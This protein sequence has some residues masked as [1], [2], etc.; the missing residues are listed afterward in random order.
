MTKY[1]WTALTAIAIVVAAVVAI[2]GISPVWTIAAAAVALLSLAMLVRSLMLPLRTIRNGMDLLRGQD[3]ASTLRKVGQSDADEMV[4]LYNALIGNMKAERL[5]NIEQADFLGKL[6]DASPMGIAI[7]DFDGRI[8]EANSSFRRMETATVAAALD[9]LA[10]GQNVTVRQ[11]DP[12]V[13][14]C[15]C[16]YF[17]DRGFRRTFYM[18][19]RLTDEVIKAETAVFNKIVRTMSHEVNNTMGGVVSVLETLADIHAAEPDVRQTLD[20]CVESCKALG[21]FMSGYSSVVKLPDASLKPVM[22]ADMVAG[23]LPFLQKLCPANITIVV[24]CRGATE[25][26]LADSALMHRVFT[27]AVK[28]AVES[29]GTRPGRIVLSVEGRRVEIADNGP[30]I[31]SADAGA[32]FTPFFSTKH[33][34]R[35]LGLMLIADIM[36]KH[37]AEFGLATGEDG[38]T[39]LSLVFPPAT[40]VVNTDCQEGN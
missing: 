18:V 20:S 4:E 33:P 11:G 7:C 1:I 24:E 5:K 9:S 34:D 22:P 23:E 40:A 28:N 31:S 27:N 3:F 36:R 26:V 21:E 29:I 2:V 15:I 17:M 12:Q 38:I 16:G 14:R 32:L 6:I 39:R 37:K 35:G 25:T 30:G 19:E 10:P 8:I 13:L